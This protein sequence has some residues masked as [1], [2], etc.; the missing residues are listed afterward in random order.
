MTKITKNRILTFVIIG[1]ILLFAAC[2]RIHT[3]YLPHNHGD[4]LFYLGLAMKL[5]KFG[6]K[7]YNLKGIDIIGD[8]NL[9]AVVESKGEKGS[10]LETLEKD[11]VFY[12]SKETL[13]NMPPA[14]SYLLMFSHRIFSPNKLFLSVNRNLGPFAILLRPKIFL[15]SQFYAVWINFAFSLLFILMVFFLGRLFFNENVGLWASLLISIA[16]VDILT[17]Q[18]LWS[19][20]MISF[21]TILSVF[22]FWRGKI[23]KNLL[24]IGLS[25]IS[26]GIA[27]ISKQSG[28]FIVVI[29]II[30][31]T[32][33]RYAKDKTIS[34][35]LLFNKELIVFVLFAISIC[36]FWYAKVTLAYGVPWNTPYQEGIE[37]V[38]SWFIMLSARDR[39]GQLYYF[40]YLLP[41]LALFYFESIITLLKR[42]FTPERI[43]C[44]IWFFLFVLFLILI[45]A[46]EARYLLPAYPAI[47]IFS[48]VAIENIRK[49]MNNLSRIKHLG[50]IAVVAA[51]F[52]CS[53]WSIKLG[54]NCV[55]SNS[56]IFRLY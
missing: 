46:K 9:L 26:A 41:A 19:D 21:F 44:L 5:E 43:F 54:L 12:Y 30:F 10:L 38:A 34:I 39:F 32:L 7:G 16:P 56:A 20:E 45:P 47:A 29:I 13:S 1:I 37:K 53:I 55:F 33:M 18:R 15:E 36:G 40:L 6:L 52:L 8:N 2:L 3:F 31:E 51:L 22:L 17:S 27:A 28:F 42:C 48:G 25:G 4:Q 14:F 49:R 11:N 50:D 24:F 23:K 35:R